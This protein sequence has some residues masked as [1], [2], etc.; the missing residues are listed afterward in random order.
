MDNAG[1]NASADSLLSVDE[2]TPLTA[3]ADTFPHT[4]SHSN[5][6][7]LV[8]D[9]EDDID[10][11]FYLSD[12]DEEEA[13][14]DDAQLDWLASSATPLSTILVYLYLFS[15]FLGL[16]AMFIPDAN[17][18]RPWMVAAILAF[19]VLS[20]F[21]RYIWY[22]LARYLRKINLEDIVADAFAKGRTKERL[23]AKLRAAV[24]V[25]DW[26]SK[27]LLAALFLRGQCTTANPLVFNSETAP[28][29][30]DLILP[31]TPEGDLL[32]SRFFWTAILLLGVLPFS[33][34]RSL[35][36]KRAVV[37]SILSVITYV[38]WFAC[39]AY[40]HGKG[41]LEASAS[42]T[43]LGSLWDGVC[44][45]NSCL[46]ASWFAQS[47]ISR[48]SIRFHRFIDSLPI[49]FIEGGTLES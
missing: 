24:W 30:V 3:N 16:G 33:T 6:I 18:S 38:A 43:T 41:S 22:L 39:T 37:P 44:K 10:T 8:P 31:L 47:E 29:S 40:S 36:S 28:V 49:Q 13:E 7:I 2:R 27:V 46:C 42:W 21:A 35:A 34:A 25:G 23:R 4:D 17:A 1:R 9:D 19:I 48:S 12:G 11:P 14:Y 15:P 5:L 20:T 26:V 45:P 32:S